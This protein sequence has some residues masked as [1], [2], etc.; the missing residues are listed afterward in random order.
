M[1]TGILTTLDYNIKTFENMFDNKEMFNN[2]IAK[3]ERELKELD[4]RELFLKDSK[5]L[6][7]QAVD[8]LYKESIG[9]LQDTLDTALQFIMFDKN[10]SIKLELEDTRGTKALNIALVDN[11]AG[12][13]VDLKD[14]VGAGLRCIISF[15]LKMYYLLNEG[16][17]VLFLDEKYSALSAQYVPLFF[18]FIKRMTEE[19]DFIL[20]MITHDER[21]MAYAD[22]IYR[23]NDGVC[24]EEKNA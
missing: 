17:K 3:Y 24:V 5:T 16:S 11:D 19:K 6:Y 14:S 22:K 1:Q 18:E 10:Y 12:F 21:F 23:I 13:E 20:V 15:V 4:D 9:V 8:F 2:E 7:A